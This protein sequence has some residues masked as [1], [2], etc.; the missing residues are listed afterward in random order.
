MKNTLNELT[1]HFFPE[2]KDNPVRACNCA[3]WT[4]VPK[5]LA[6]GALRDRGKTEEKCHCVLI[7]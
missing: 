7:F 5:S 1:R 6:D 2:H 4:Q 3:R